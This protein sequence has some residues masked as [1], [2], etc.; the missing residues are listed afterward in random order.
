MDVEVLSF[1]LRGMKFTES[2]IEYT[3]SSLVSVG[4][5]LTAAELNTK[6][7]VALNNTQARGAQGMVFRLNFGGVSK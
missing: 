4:S 7:D 1:T 5:E 3:L 2:E 6:L